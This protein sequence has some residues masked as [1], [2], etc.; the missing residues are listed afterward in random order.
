MPDKPRSNM[1]AIRHHWDSTGRLCAAACV[2][3]LASGCPWMIRYPSLAPEGSA[4]SRVSAQTQ[5][6]FPS[7]NIGP[8]VGSRPPQFAKE[9]SQERV[10]ADRSYAAWLRMQAHPPTLS[11]G[12][13]GPLLPRGSY[14][15]PPGVSAYPPS[16]VM[17]QGTPVQQSGVPVARPF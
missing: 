9:R 5:D 14:V 2:L 1:E 8:D 3:L 12:P 15:V 11:P 4:S 6:P 16:G 13:N 7:D 10:A 17:V